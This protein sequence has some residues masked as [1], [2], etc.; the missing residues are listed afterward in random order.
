MFICSNP[1][2]GGAVFLKRQVLGC[3]GSKY[4]REHEV[5]LDPSGSRR[6]RVSLT[7]Y[8]ARKGVPACEVAGGHSYPTGALEHVTSA[9]FGAI[10]AICNIIALVALE[11]CWCVGRAHEGVTDSTAAWY[12]G[13]YTSKYLVCIMLT[14]KALS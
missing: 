14:V 9:D 10:C 8:P 12:S 4:P 5:E 13:V 1:A 6:F 3:L 7:V 2:F 11:Y